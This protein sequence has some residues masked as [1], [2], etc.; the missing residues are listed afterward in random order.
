MS[1]FVVMSP[2][3]MEDLIRRT[4]QETLAFADS[5]ENRKKLLTGEEVQAEYGIN[6]RNL[7]GWRARGMGPEYT[8]IGRRVYYER[9]VIED[10]IVAGRVN[11][12]DTA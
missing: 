6:A 12:R 11:T 2:A 7:E 4:I 9:S 10:Y 5:R 1:A 3:E 8:T